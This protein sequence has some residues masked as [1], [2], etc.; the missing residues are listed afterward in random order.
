MIS[1][2]NLT[3]VIAIGT[4]VIAIGTVVIAGGTILYAIDFFGKRKK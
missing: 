2:F 3:L 4:V 1:I